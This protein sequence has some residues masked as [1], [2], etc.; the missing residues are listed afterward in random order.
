MMVTIYWLNQFDWGADGQ[1]KL[2][3]F[4][5]LFYCDIRFTVFYDII[6]ALLTGSVKVDDRD[7]NKLFQSRIKIKFQLKLQVTDQS[8][9]LATAYRVEVF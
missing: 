3:C 4:F 1:E 9:D 8:S 2:F 6:N 7:V 5:L